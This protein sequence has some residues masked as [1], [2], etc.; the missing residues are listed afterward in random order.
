MR[1]MTMV[2]LCAL[3][4]GL[5]LFAADDKAK[6]ALID[7][8][9]KWGEAGTR[10]DS[11]TVGSL[12]ADDVISVDGTGVVG[13]AELLAESPPEEAGAKYEPENYKV[14]FLDE[15]TAIMTHSTRGSDP[16]WSMHVWAKRDGRW[17]VV[18]TS[19]T[20]AAA[21]EGEVAGE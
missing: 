14:H 1:T 10:G 12:L 8:D 7:L 21:V 16:H 5:P 20:P 6:Q 2:L 3:W 17:L 19:S 11:T 15:D 13:K 4:L 9:K 18:A